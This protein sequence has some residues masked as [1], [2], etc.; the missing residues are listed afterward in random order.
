MTRQIIW[1][2]FVSL[3]SPKPRGQ[4]AEPKGFSNI[5][6]SGIWV[7]KDHHGQSTKGGMNGEGD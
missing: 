1:V 7:I 5:D 6:P 4:D 3:L 2:I